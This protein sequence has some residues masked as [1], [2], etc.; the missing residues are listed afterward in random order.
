[1]KHELN[2]KEYIDRYLQGEMGPD[3]KI[4]FEKEIDGN[5]SLKDE[6]RL[7]TQVDLVL[8]DREL[9]ELKSQLDLIHHEIFVVS[10]KGK[11]TI[12]KIYRQIY[13]SAGVMVLMAL[14][15]TLY[16]S[17]RNFT[18]NKLLARF[19]EPANPTASYRSSATEQNELQK[20]MDFYKNHEYQSAIALFETILEKDSSKLGLNLYSGISHMEIKEYS[21]ANDRFNKILANQPNPFVESAKWYLGMCY[22]MTDEREKAADQF[23]TL[24]NTKG[25][26]QN[27]AK[28]ILKRIK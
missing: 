20:A 2:Y 24:A 9:L 8:A 23:E 28:R 17:N 3:E 5:L 16:L 11:G 19:Y 1:M 15:F 22:L 14:L 4:W 18:S 6:I 26:Y 7:R 21:Q 25:F 27:D 13:A 10:E 12:S